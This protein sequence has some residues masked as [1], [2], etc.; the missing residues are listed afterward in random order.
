MTILRSDFTSRCA[1]LVSELNLGRAADILSIAPLSGGVASDIGKVV[2]TDRV[3]C[4]K[5]ALAKLKVAEDWQAPVHRN[6]AEY[7]WLQTAAQIAPDAAPILFGRSDALNGFAMEFLSGVDIHLWKD[8]L[9]QSQAPQGEAEKVA[10]LLGQIH[11]ASAEPGFDRKPF[12]NKD[13]FAA[14]RLAP[15]LRFTA[16][17]HPDIADKLN[18]MADR[19]YEREAVLV[20][21]DVSPKNILLRGGSPIILDA[22]CATMGDAGFDVAFCLNHLVLKAIHLPNMRAIYL[23]QVNAFWSAY[24][25][26]IHWE[27]AEALEQHVATLLPMLMLARV[28]GK[29]P[30]EYLSP[31]SSAQVREVALSLIKTP[32]PSLAAVVGKIS[33]HLEG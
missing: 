8:L 12:Q 11:A 7:H 17:R 16:S 20:H 6:K 15:Y 1:A 33:N 31:A 29:S 28:D 9:L 26:H 25:P 13:D 2:L 32:Q 14:L 30:V 23:N 3:I 24:A 22:E 21:G 5:F 19:I 10:R 27:D 4:I 18:S